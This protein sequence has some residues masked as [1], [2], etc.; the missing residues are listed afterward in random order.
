MNERGSVSERG[1]SVCGREKVCVSEK[2]RMFAS[3]KEC[4]CVCICVSE[5]EILCGCVSERVCVC[6]SESVSGRV[7]VGHSVCGREYECAR[8]REGDRV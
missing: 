2:E 7:S 6:V 5:R 1:E 4:V 8:D 3:K